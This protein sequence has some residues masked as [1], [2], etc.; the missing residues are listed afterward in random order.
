MDFLRLEHPNNNIHNLR[1]IQAIV[2]RCPS[3]SDEAKQQQE[4]A[5]STVPGGVGSCLAVL[6]ELGLVQRLVEVLEYAHA[7]QVR[8][9]QSPHR[10]YESGNF[11]I[12]CL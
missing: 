1:L 8:C 2:V 7:N 10:G 6:Y 9:C 12:S 4:L 5:G 3:A 11:A